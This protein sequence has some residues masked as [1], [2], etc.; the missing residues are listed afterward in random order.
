M[1]R[2][3][4]GEAERLARMHFYNRRHFLKEGAVGLGGLALGALLACH[5]SRDAS[6]IVFDPA[7]PLEPK[8]PPFAGKAKSIIYL[9][10]AGAPRQL[11]LFDYK[12]E[13]LKMAGRD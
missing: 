13:L 2:I 1:G 11:E 10:M 3:N 8:L 12:T 5:G 6:K 9:H 4:Y 7:H